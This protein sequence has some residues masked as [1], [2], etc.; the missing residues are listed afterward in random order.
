M[1][2]TERRIKEFSTV[3]N[4]PKLFESALQQAQGYPEFIEG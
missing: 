3:F 4:A 1:N 2:L